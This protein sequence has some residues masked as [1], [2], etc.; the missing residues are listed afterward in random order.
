M[1]RTFQQLRHK[2]RMQGVACPVRDKTPQ[3]RLAGLMQIVK[4]I[5]LPLMPI[6]QGQGVGLDVHALLAKMAK[7]MDQPDLAEIISIQ[8]PPKQVENPGEGPGVPGAAPKPPETTRNYVR[9]S[10]PGRTRQGNDRNMVSA[11]MGVNPGGSAATGAPRNGQAM[12]VGA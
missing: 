7:Y 10:M 5:L 8:E 11:L 1:R 2:P 4:E 3:H 6:A 12:G 9:E